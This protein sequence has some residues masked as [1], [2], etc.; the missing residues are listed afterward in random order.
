MR[1]V[2][3]RS[4]RGGGK[5]KRYVG[6]TL[7]DGRQVLVPMGEPK[8]E[9]FHNLRRHVGERGEVT[10][11]CG[12]TECAAA[13]MAYRPNGESSATLREAARAHVAKL[14]KAA[15]DAVAECHWAMTATILRRRNGAYEPK[16]LKHNERSLK[17]KRRALRAY[18]AYK[19]AE[20]M[21]H[22]MG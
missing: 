14:R 15:E 11:G 1:D 10:E 21:L 2:M 13:G 19:R 20:E 4:K 8:R 5:V 6:R 16:R 9:E 12:C 18:E 17:L 3:R 7:P 22:V